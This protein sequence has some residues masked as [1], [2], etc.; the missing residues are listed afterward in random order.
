MKQQIKKIGFWIICAIGAIL[1]LYVALFTI[2]VIP[3]IIFSPFIIFE[4]IKDNG[5]S[6]I[7]LYYKLVII[8]GGLIF[9]VIVLK[10]L[11]S[12][13]KWVKNKIK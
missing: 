8:C 13:I 11:W 9:T 6:E 5:W 1:F 7:S 4:T 3:A 2:S 10:E 12:F